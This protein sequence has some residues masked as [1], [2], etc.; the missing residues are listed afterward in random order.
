MN[1][2]IL[3]KLADS[4]D[5]K[6]LKSALDTL[7]ERFQILRTQFP[8]NKERKLPLQVVTE[9]CA[10]QVREVKL[11]SH[12]K[13]EDVVHDE[14]NKGFNHQ[15]EVL[16]RTIIIKSNES[17]FLM[18][19][20]SSMILDAGSLATLADSLNDLLNGKSLDEEI[21]QYS[22]IAEWQHDLI[23]EAEEDIADF[24]KNYASDFHVNPSL[25]FMNSGSVEIESRKLSHLTSD[26]DNAIQRCK[27]FT[28]TL[29]ADIADQIRG[30]ASNLDTDLPALTV[31]IVSD[32]LSR[33]TASDQLHISII[34]PVRGF[35]E[36]RNVVGNLSQ[37]IPWKY[38]KASSH[39]ALKQSLQQIQSI[40]EHSL[41]YNSDRVATGKTAA[42]TSD[43]EVYLS[44][45]STPGSH[46]ETVHLVSGRG[47]QGLQISILDRGSDIVVQFMSDVHKVNS[48]WI[49]EL[50]AQMP[51][52][53]AH[54]LNHTEK[55]EHQSSW[56]NES[57]QRIVATLSGATSAQTEVAL[58]PDLLA[59]VFAT[60]SNQMAL[61]QGMKWLNFKQLQTASE[62]VAR[63][64]I[65]RGIKPGS[66]VGVLLP[67]S[68]DA[69][70]SILGILRSGACYVPIDVE[71]PESRIGYMIEDAELALLITS[72]SR[73]F[74]AV[75]SATPGELNT[76]STD[77]TL[78][79]AEA[80]SPAYI[81]YT[82]G[83]TGN[84]K[85]CMITHRQL[86]WYLD[87]ARKNYFDGIS[88]SSVPLFT[89]LAFD[90]TVTSIF[91][92]LI[93]GNCLTIF[94][95]SMPLNEVIA[96][97][98][99]PSGSTEVLKMTPAHTLLLPHS[100]LRSTKVKR[101]IVGGEALLPVHVE[102]L[103]NLNPK[104]QI[105][106]EYGP[107]ETV[108]G[109]SVDVIS[110]KDQPITIGKPVD[111]A[112]MYIV[113]HNLRILP[114]GV[115]G[116]LVIGGHS[117]SNGYL[118]RADLNHSKFVVLN[119]G[120][121]VYRSGDLAYL[122]PDGNFM[123][124]GRTDNQVKIRGYR[125]ELDEIRTQIQRINGV[126]DAFVSTTTYNDDAQHLIAYVVSTDIS[127]E[128]DIKSP[129][130]EMLP[131]YMIPSFVLFVPEIPLTVN[132]KVDT[133]AL[134]DLHSYIQQHSQVVREPE[135][136]L[137]MELQAIW[138][139]VLGLDKISID[140]NFFAVGGHS[141]KAMQIVSRV[142]HSLK[143]N[144]LLSD[145]FDHLT[146]EQLDIHLKSKNK[147]EDTLIPK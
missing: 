59:D 35:D 53:F 26:A 123:F 32:F 68:I 147:S 95:E 102:Q 15:S 28:I 116:E 62:N 13:V 67:R 1:A 145:F 38:Q 51:D 43:I 136:E 99:D 134:P 90:L 46:F 47:T 37:S 114:V 39:S 74:D 75:P 29:S 96:S 139:D 89:S 10:Y 25:T 57:R 98:F 88:D 143:L 7:V 129:L 56:L 77:S 83:S 36:L 55:P 80:D 49:E 65:A 91:G 79:D 142:Q 146:I 93:T 24:W 16:F 18:I 31:V 50:S 122:L 126:K 6:S 20:A 124:L 84:P 12:K 8:T 121:R 117:V 22:Q 106:N 108:V 30:Q 27:L 54:F 44:T 115:P 86:A 19:T 81:I 120:E 101:V 105:F 118:N 131:A 69:I 94:E 4:V 14:L 138:M 78:P 52:F 97:I 100:G 85:G 109:C 60:K 107:T 104:M 130:S 21:L 133:K 127:E 66:H 72:D 17:R 111:H 132:G 103:L 64:L 33:Y 112:S 61:M 119:N 135:N 71:Y 3:L 63:Q 110:S 137:Q 140:D 73:Y 23:N 2:Q 9:S 70:V 92:S 42:A 144:L 113:D 76:D 40:R 58:L 34:D 128:E 82:S 125:I 141:L 48:S 11:G 5:E 41:Y 87:W 45:D